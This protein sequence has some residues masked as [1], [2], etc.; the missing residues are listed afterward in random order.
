M[1]RTSV[2]PE[3]S[4]TGDTRRSVGKVGVGAAW[5]AANS[6]MLRLGN[7]LV[8]AVVA[9]ILAPA[10]FGVFALALVAFTMVTSVAELGVASAIARRD[11]DADA[12]GP[13]VVTISLATS[14]GLGAA[15]A[16]F[17]EPLAVA[18]GSAHAADALRIL[19]LS[20]VLTGVFAA[21]GAQLQRDFRQ[22]V[23]FRASAVGFL[24]GVP[25]LVLLALGGGGAEAFAWSRVVSQLVTGVVMILG[26]SRVYLPGW[27][28]ACLRL[29]LGFGIPLAA[30]N[31]L[32]QVVVNVDTVIV[33]HTLSLADVGVYN[34]M[35]GVASWSSAVLG[36]ILNGIVLPAFSNVRAVGGDLA[37]ALRRGGFTVA[38]VAAPIA[39]LTVG[40]AHPLVLTVYGP[41]WEAGVP[42]LIVLGGY[43]VV[44]TVCLYL[45]NIIIATGRTFV[46]LVVQVA[47]L[48][49]LVPV[50]L[51][52]ATFAGLV[53]VA[54]GHLAVVALVTLPV[55][56]VATR[57]A[58]GVPIRR[59]ISA[60]LSPF[61]AAA[62]AGLTAWAIAQ[63]PLA[64]WLQLLLGGAAGALSYVLVLWP[65]HRKALPFSWRGLLT[66]LRG[67]QQAAERN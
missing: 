51:A 59:F 16:I 6:L 38:L 48:L 5:L 19:S 12:I 34:L 49:A 17:A 39:A 13:T 14:L 58:T 15:V 24:A 63:L 50:L 18:L 25:V 53:G 43:G 26:V 30:A 60:G 2:Q 42:T 29:L 35:F 52:A 56:L 23:V 36:S 32:S 41:Q 67:G 57:R 4:R 46:I 62:A 54:L 33:G 31:L 45:A 47:V 20:V 44:S 61:T 10:E 37:A 1:N 8:M 64:S 28:R 27:N 22:G 7:I 21:P 11:L 9:R 66:G 3:A 40:L 65:F 55:Y